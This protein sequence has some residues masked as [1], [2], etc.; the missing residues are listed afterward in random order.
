M[1]IIHVALTPLAGSPMRIVAALNHH[2]T[3]FQ[4]RLIV[5]DPNAYG[6]RTFDGDLEWSRDKQEALQLLRNA[7][8]LH[9]H[10]YFELQKNPFG[11]DFTCV[12]PRAQ[13]VR[14][15]HTHP[16]TIAQGDAQRARQIVESAIPQLVI[17]QYHERF[18]PQARIVPNIVPLADEL[19]RPVP[20]E[21]ID[22]VVFFAPTV[23]D[24][25]WS[26]T[27]GSTRWE[28][29]GA[30]ETE[31]LLRQVV[32]AC[33]KGRITVRR[34][35]PHEQCLREKRASD[36]VID[37]MITGSFHLTGLEALAQGLATF[38]YL[39]SR[40]LET[41]SEL[42][43]TYTNPWL[44]FRLEEA[45]GPLVELIR[46]A[47]LRREIGAFSRKWMEKYYN[48]REMINQYVRAY[49]DLLERPES[50][51]KPRFD[52]GSRRQ[53]FL[54]QRR[55]D[56]V[57]DK[58]KTRI[59]AESSVSRV[60]LNG[61]AA[62]LQ[63]KVGTMPNWIKAPVHDLLKKYTSVRVD[64]IQTLEKRLATAERLL[65]FVSADETSRWLYQNRLERMDAT[66]DFFDEK[67]RKFHLD[68][69]R[70]AAQRVKGKR[71]LDCACGTGYGTRMLSELGGSASV[72]GIDIDKD[73][74]MYALKKHHVQ[75]TSYL[76][77]SG[78]VL[79]LSDASMD[80]VVS[81]E[82]IEHVP[83]DISLVEEF[84]RVL[85]ARGI[86]IVS[87]PNQW[88]L[89]TAPHH[90]REYDRGSFL[91]VIEPKFDCL[92]LYNQNSGS[93]TAH[94]RGQPRGIVETTNTNDQFAECYIAICRRKPATN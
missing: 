55:D 33:G 63:N 45:E 18:Y 61:S 79:P 28:T 47:Q 27:Q 74:I 67:R 78:D 29:K 24:S 75:S 72:T 88:P 41:L 62:V 48:D 56:L 14:Q 60:K 38:A 11:V 59:E 42:T 86:L 22:P 73:A 6:S 49:E 25:A 20:R 43:G 44:N 83:D 53:V 36:I 94:N 37:E 19:Y 58:R 68:R 26:V 87:T 54:A 64:E 85:R 9:F 3:K 76:C 77:A 69:Y 30:R 70:F 34:N 7:D 65:E 50:F 66:L 84:Y 39:D 16:L 46:D 8:L 52:L 93:N 13:F 35:I 92:E 32:N 31:T 17:A 10:H 80:I 4:S 71:V 5:C 1:T 40:S 57:W 89:A 2:T 90:V 91:R 12:S 82:T 81:F 23:D 15:F 51:Q 21:G